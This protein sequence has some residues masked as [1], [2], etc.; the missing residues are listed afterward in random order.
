M[1]LKLKTTKDIQNFKAKASQQA[2]QALNE[3]SVIVDFSHKSIP[4]MVASVH[5]HIMDWN[6]KKTESA[7]HR[8][9]AI[10]E[11]CALKERVEGEGKDWWPWF[12]ENILYI[13]RKTAAGWLTIGGAPDPE[14]ALEAEKARVRAAEAKSRATV[15]ED[16]E[17]SSVA[18][19]DQNEKP[20]LRVVET[21]DPALPD[22][23]NSLSREPIQ[24]VQSFVRKLEDWLQTKPNISEDAKLS[25]ASALL[26]C[27]AQY[28]QM[29]KDILNY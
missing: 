23:I 14:A 3:S 29:S 1:P 20:Q 10:L 7:N 28:K 17:Y 27:S 8:L 15:E 2:L 19:D 12:D 22:I 16:D 25:L 6:R 5:Q 4:D 13:K 9:D 11:L 26:E 24:F 21:Y 18:T